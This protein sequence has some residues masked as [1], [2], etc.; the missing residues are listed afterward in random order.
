MILPTL[1]QSKLST[2][3][4]DT[5]IFHADTNHAKVRDSI[6]TDLR[7]VDKWYAENRIKR[8]HS[9]YQAIVMGKMQCKLEF[10]CENTVIPIGEQL[11]LLGVNYKVFRT[12]LRDVDISCHMR[13]YFNNFSLSILSIYFY[14]HSYIIL[15]N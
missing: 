10:I 3:A 8:N 11:D 7:Y 15:N 14:L 12:A 2:C 1:K 5:Q 13:T 9:K 4:D 6:N